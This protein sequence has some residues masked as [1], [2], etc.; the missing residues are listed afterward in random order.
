[1][2]DA[3][4]GL[5]VV[6]LFVVWMAGVIR[7]GDLLIYFV[8]RRLGKIP[9]CTPGSCYCPGSCSMMLKEPQS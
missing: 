7:V 4:L 8:G 6:L 3:I 1:M 9:P 2:D 5:L